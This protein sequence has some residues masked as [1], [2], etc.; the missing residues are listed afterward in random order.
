M[1]NSRALLGLLILV[2]I[3]VACGGDD[4][5]SECKF[6]DTD[7]E[8]DAGQT[9]DLFGQFPIQWQLCAKPSTQE[10]DLMQAGSTELGVFGGDV[11]FR[12]L[13]DASADSE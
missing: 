6:C 10:C 9:C 12:T 8:C 13:P 1:K 5:G 4:D 7:A 3:C 2:L 11:V